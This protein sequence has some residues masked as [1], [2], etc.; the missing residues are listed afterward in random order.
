[1]KARIVKSPFSGQEL[2]LFAC[3]E[4][5]RD[6]SE[7]APKVPLFMSHADCAAAVAQA[8]GGAL[9]INAI[10]S[11]EGWQRC[12]FDPGVGGSGVGWLPK[13]SALGCIEAD[14]CNY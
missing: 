6:G 4:L 1:M 10:L 2:P 12:S 7:G 13:R 9:E 14:F 8:P 11:L 5:T 3:M